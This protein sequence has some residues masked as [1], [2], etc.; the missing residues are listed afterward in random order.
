MAKLA[1]TED[2]YATRTFTCFPAL[3]IE[4]RLDIW[5]RACFLP[6][7]VDVR[8]KLIP[9]VLPAE[10]H[11]LAPFGPDDFWAFRYASAHPAP[12]VLHANRE[13]RA[14]GLQHYELEF[15]TRHEVWDGLSG[16]VRAAT[17]P[18][19]YINPRCD[20]I[21]RVGPFRRGAEYDFRNVVTR[22]KPRSIAF[23]ACFDVPNDYWVEKAIDPSPQSTDIL[24]Y[25]DS[26]DRTRLTPTQTIRFVPWDD[27]LPIY[28]LARH[29][30][31][32]GR[33]RI[34]AC[35]RDERGRTETPYVARRV[36]LVSL[37]VDGG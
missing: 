26:R 20:R 19:I 5:E 16:Y 9:P 13:A 14:V 17:P 33:E 29:A 3:P 7:N 4:I 34:E 37:I 1:P 15:A 27:S 28:P 24:L 30:L 8:V 11:I 18:Q 6:R 2:I 25:Y 36:R 32:A 10:E 35:A 23:N 22:T 21:C 12:A 31:V